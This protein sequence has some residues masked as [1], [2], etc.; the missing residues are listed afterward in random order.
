MYHD[1]LVKETGG[2]ISV[3]A[4]TVNQFQHFSRSQAPKGDRFSLR[5]QNG[6]ERLLRGNQN[7]AK[8]RRHSLNEYDNVRSQDLIDRIKYTD[9]GLRGNFKGNIR[10]LSIQEPSTTLRQLLTSIPEH[11]AFDLEIKYPMVWEA[12]D[13]KMSYDILE[14]N[15]YVDTI[16]DTIFLH[17]KHRNITLT[18]SSPEVCIALACK[19]SS[20]PILQINKAGT[21]PVGDV[22]AGSRKGALDSVTAWKLDGE[23][24]IPDPVVMCPRL[25]KYAKDM[26]LIVASYGD[27]NNEVDCAKVSG[28]SFEPMSPCGGR[29]ETTDGLMRS[30][31]TKRVYCPEPSNVIK[32]STC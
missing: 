1:F 18:S 24:I 20:F 27:L 2:D 19:Q 10:G 21:V 7:G 26:G 6:I 4:L 13:R 12:E 32:C 17:C 29:L 9:E 28:S 11:I 15:T 5:E 8:S 22:R 14:L 23:V 25:L 16:L 30:S 31:P 3:H